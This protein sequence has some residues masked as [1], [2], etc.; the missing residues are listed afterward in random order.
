M[1]WLGAERA[2]SDVEVI[3]LAW[4]LLASLGVGGLQLELNSLGTAEDR[5]AY[6]NALVAWLEQRSEALDPDSQARLS[7]NPLRILDSKT[8]TPR[9]FWKTRPPWRMPYLMPAVS[10]LRRCSAG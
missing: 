2:R 7:T 10:V 8:R 1:E 9:R 5:Q 4:D 3:A 6:R